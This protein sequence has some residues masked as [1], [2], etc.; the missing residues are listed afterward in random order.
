MLTRGVFLAILLALASA[1]G[2]AAWLAARIVTTPT[3]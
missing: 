2:L 3:R 1:P